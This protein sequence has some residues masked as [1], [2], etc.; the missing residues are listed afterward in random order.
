[1]S[2]ATLEFYLADVGRS[3]FLP[4]STELAA[5]AT[6]SIHARSEIA[7]H[8]DPLPLCW[9]AEGKERGATVE[10]WEVS[11]DH[12]SL[13]SYSVI[14]VRSFVTCVDCTEWLHA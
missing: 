14:D 4:W 12:Q 10:D 1:M 13:P 7:D 3:G 11:F 9:V 5:V 6:E 2:T 8:L